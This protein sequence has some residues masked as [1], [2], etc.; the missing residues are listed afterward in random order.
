VQKLGMNV[1]HIGNLGAVDW[2]EEDR[3]TMQDQVSI[4]GLDIV[5]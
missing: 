2:A 1:P 4:V 5:E 3:S